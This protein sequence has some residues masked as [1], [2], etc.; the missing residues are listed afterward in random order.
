MIYSFYI[1]IKNKFFEKKQPIVKIDS[2]HSVILNLGY[3]PED[4]TIV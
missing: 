3:L 4:G 2:N 1:Y